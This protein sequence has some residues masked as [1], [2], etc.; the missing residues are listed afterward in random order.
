[1]KAAVKKT[2]TK[3]V[4]ATKTTAK[5]TAAKKPAAKK[6]PAAKKP[7]ASKTAEPKIVLQFGEMSIDQATLLQNVT[8]YLAYDK[9]MPAEDQKGVEV[10]VKPEEGRA[11]IVVNGEEEG[12]ILL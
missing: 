12:S 5:K 3:R 1:M 6:A 7:A 8:N 9:N 4:T 2:E 10:Y 11:Y